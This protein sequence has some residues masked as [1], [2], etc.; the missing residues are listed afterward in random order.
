MKVKV[1]PQEERNLESCEQRWVSKT[2]VT[3]A[4]SHSGDFGGKVVCKCKVWDLKGCL[5]GVGL[6]QPLRKRGVEK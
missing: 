5:S 3:K 6:E 4:L 2:P 1:I